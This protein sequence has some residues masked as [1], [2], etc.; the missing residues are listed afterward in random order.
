MEE[1]EASNWWK[2]SPNENANALTRC[3]AEAFIRQV[4]HTK[5]FFHLDKKNKVPEFQKVEDKRS[6]EE[7]FKKQ[8]SYETANLRTDLKTAHRER[9]DFEKSLKELQKSSEEA[10]KKS[11]DE[12]AKL[13]SDLNAVKAELATAQETF[14]A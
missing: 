5:N 3:L 10:A 14:L 11:T 13:T 7:E 8:L 9:N 2:A 1:A 12:I 6:L 4:V